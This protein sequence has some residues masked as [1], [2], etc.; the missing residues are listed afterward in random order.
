MLTRSF[1]SGKNY[2]HTEE[3]DDDTVKGAT[4][5]KTILSLFSFG[6][7]VLFV[8]H[9]WADEGK[10]R[11]AIHYEKVPYRV[12][13]KIGLRFDA[14]K[15]TPVAGVQVELLVNEVVVGTALTNAKGSY[16]L[17]WKQ[18]KGT[19]VK[20]RLM[21]ISGHV[22]VRN[23]ERVVYSYPLGSLEV[24]QGD[25][26]RD[27]VLVTVDKGAGAL[28]IIEA[29]RIADEFLKTEAGVK[30]AE[31]PK[32][33]I[34]WT[35]G[36]N[37][38]PGTITHFS[39]HDNSAFIYGDRAVDS[40]EFDDYVI[41]HEYGHFIMSVFSRDDSPGGNHGS[42]QKI[43][44]RLAWSEGWANFFACAVIGDSHYADTQL[45]NLSFDLN[46][47]RPQNAGYWN[48]MSVG[49][50]LWNLTAKEP[51]GLHV[52]VPFKEIWEV[53]IGPWAN[54]PQGTLIDFC[55]LLVQRK[56]ELGPRLAK[57]LEA[58]S[59][60]YMPGKVPSVAGY[61]YRRPLALGVPQ[62]DS[63]DSAS[64]GYQRF[65]GSHVYAFTLD[66][67]TKVK[68][69]LE[70][71]GSDKK[72]P[73]RLDLYL[74]NSKKKRADNLMDR[75]SVDASA[76]ID[77]LE[78]ELEPG[79]YFVEVRSFASG[80][81]TGSYQ[82]LA[83]VDSTVPVSRK[84]LSIAQLG[85]IL[86]EYGYTFTSAKDNVSVQLGGGYS[87][88]LRLYADGTLVAGCNN[89]ARLSIEQINKWNDDNWRSRAIQHDKSSRLEADLDCDLG[90]TAPMVSRFLRRYEQ[91]LEEFERFTDKQVIKDFSAEHVER[92]IKNVMKT[93]ISSK[94]ENAKK[95]IVYGTPD[96]YFDVF[97][98]RDAKTISFKLGF[99]AAAERADAWNRQK[100]KMS[101]AEAAG[102]GIVNIV[103]T[104]SI[105]EGISV[106]G[107][108]T[109]HDRLKAEEKEFARFMSQKPG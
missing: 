38:P 3:R 48:E 99:R 54:L 103:G 74:F 57:V 93:S 23:K 5:N 66:K 91:K 2:P 59:I 36:Y 68:L 52:S 64:F 79:E 86:K 42:N 60:V 82:L 95:Q 30:A 26:T 87:A 70:E 58:Q 27:T 81:N 4:V 14:P 92:F 7:F 94:K 10:I 83:A 35:P 97:Y 73:A 72:K 25:V 51:K 67:K 78:T 88:D 63:V 77:W 40:D 53:V 90:V 20:L 11:G 16:E 47:V 108:K 84:K 107:L 71:V 69:R 100:G 33:T 8:P 109:F 80:F 44:P 43:D 21:A 106:S 18:D 65:E 39:S 41:I 22:E 29:I 12:D 89:F 62:K 45:E 32:I 101:K 46:S 19:K 75:T 13:N 1:T 76:R 105:A 56:P 31:I 17:P 50:T 6:W 34:S 102:N 85:A 96:G 24:A 9:A 55:D 15:T 98:D 61:Q 28:N 49:F 37:G 104:I